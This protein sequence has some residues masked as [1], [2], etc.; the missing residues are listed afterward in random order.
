MEDDATIGGVLTFSLRT[1]GHSVV[2]AASGARRCPRRWAAFDLALL[3][4]GLP[5]MDGLDV[6]RGL[7][8]T[9]PAA[10]W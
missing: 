6:C 8:A 10:C 1:Q 5:D 4:L 7:R 2:L 9:Q 3:D